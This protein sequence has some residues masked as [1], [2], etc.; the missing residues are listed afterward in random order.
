MVLC[1][2]MLLS[3]QKE[4]LHF[5]KL[6]VSDGLPQNH[7]FSMT[8]DSDGYVWLC[9]MSGLSKYNGKRFENYR[10]DVKDSTSIPASW[11]YKYFEDSKG[12]SYVA[13][14]KGFSESDKQKGTF[15]TYTHKREGNSISSRNTRDIL[16]VSDGRIAIATRFGVDLFNPETKEFTDYRHEKF[17]IGRFTPCLLY[18]DENQLWAGS[19]N[20]LFKVIEGEKELKYYPLIGKEGKNLTINNL[21]QDEEGTI[22]IASNRGLYTFNPSEEKFTLVDYGQENK[23]ARPF[24]LLEYPKGKL[25][26]GTNRGLFYWDIKTRK[27]LKSY[28]YAPDNPEGISVSNVYSLMKDKDNN[29]WVGLF[30]GV[31]IMNPEGENFTTYYN[32]TGLNNLKNTVLKICSDSKGR[33]WTNT[34]EGLFLK[35][36]PNSEPIEI[37]LPYNDYKK[38]YKNISKIIEDENSDIWIVTSKDGLFKTEN[39]SINFIKVKDVKDLNVSR[40]ENLVFDVHNPNI[41]WIDTD[42]GLCKFNKQTNDTTWVRPHEIDSAKTNYIGS[43]AQ[44]ESGNIWFL[45]NRQLCEYN[46]EAN[47]LKRYNT[48]KED[49]TAWY[50]GWAYN[51]EPSKDRI[52][53]SGD[54]FSYLDLKTDTFT[55]F[56][57]YNTPGKQKINKV[58]IVQEAKNGNIWFNNDGVWEFNPKTNKFKNYNVD[59]LSEG[60]ITNSFGKSKDG[61]LFFGSSG[62]V[63]TVDSNT[64]KRSKSPSKVVLSNFK[65]LNKTKEFDVKTQYVNNIRLSPE[66]NIFTIEFTALQYTNEETLNYQYKLEGFDKKW[67]DSDFT[68]LVTYTNLS[69]GNY[70]F[71]VKAVN[72]QGVKSKEPL[73]LSIYIEP[74]FWQSKLF[75]FL[76]FIGISTFFFLIYR[77][78]KRLQKLK[79]EKLVAEQSAIYKSKFLAN[80][81]HE[82]RTPMNAIMGLN[83]LM[84]S[85]ELTEKQQEYAKG[86]DLSCENLLWIINDI[87]DQSKIESGKMTIRKQPFNIS[88]IV[89]QISLLLKIK[90]NEKELDFNVH[91]DSKIPKSLIGDPT[92][93]FQILTNLIGNAIKF[94]EKGSIDLSIKLKNS[95]NESATLLFEVKDTGIGIPAHKIKEIFKSFEQVY[96]KKNENEYYSEGTG[97]GLSISKELVEQMGGTILLKSEEGKGSNFFFDLTF[98]IS[99]DEH[100]PEE[101]IKELS[102]PENLKILLVED[103]PINR[104]LAIELLN[105]HLKNVTIEIAENGIIALE[106]IESK[107]FNLVLMD[108]KMPVMDGL[109]ATKLIREMSDKYFKALPI[110][111]L[112]A[113]AIPQQIQEAKDMGMNDCITKPIYLPELL[114]AIEKFTK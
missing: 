114:G 106:K 107:D 26:I 50:S 14:V 20:G 5:T 65:V 96:S 98:N 48:S 77:N 18:D 42:T 22:W 13:T 94:T 27:L 99:H 67:M 104:F 21:L 38:G 62:G 28:V 108:I 112:S 111:G 56:N 61:K 33:L 79:E 100:T 31:N 82:F 74:N 39:S 89:D 80:M 47:S 16:E 66:E 37:V 25:Y 4:K 70:T 12:R 49:S 101:K 54:S 72:P 41:L 73:K 9:T 36:T 30:R 11:A 110:L 7:I 90:M 95:N 23:E 2:P 15:V 46:P 63:F 32:A 81:S 53:L 29:I 57:K 35:E 17:G 113:N 24:A 83:K 59:N 103:T 55:N 10:F 3:A 75:F 51:I 86:I 44:H 91:I 102:L 19:L 92:R 45:N 6:D 34:M 109:E 71:I 105:Q 97:L 1:L 58:L 68:N 60:F 87:L 43:L 52:Y 93:V 76:L 64:I 88:D 40:F 84:I 78:R 8:Q 85:S 69:P